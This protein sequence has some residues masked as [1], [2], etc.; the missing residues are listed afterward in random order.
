M[1]IAVENLFHPNIRITLTLIDGQI[2]YYSDPEHVS[3][4]G[5][6]FGADFDGT[7]IE[8]LP[9]ERYGVLNSS[10]FN[11]ILH[12]N[13]KELSAYSDKL[14]PGA[15]VQCWVYGAEV[16]PTVRA[17]VRE[18]TK[19]GNEIVLRCESSTAIFDKITL[20]K[21]SVT[22]AL[23]DSTA[24]D[25]GAPIPLNF[26]YCRKV[27]LPCVKND[28]TA[29]EY[30]YLLGYPDQEG[31]WED[32]THGVWYGGVQLATTTDYTY[33]D[34]DHVSNTYGYPVIRFTTQQY[35]L[36]GRPLQI[37]A[38]IKGQMLGGTAASRDFS[39]ILD[40]ILTSTTWGIGNAAGSSTY[41]DTMSTDLAAI[42]NMNCDLSITKRVKAL[43]VIHELVSICRCRISIDITD[44]GLTPL[45][46]KSGIPYVPIE[47]VGAT[48]GFYNNADVINTWSIQDIDRI[49][50]ITV[51]Y[52][53][54][55]E[56][57]GQEHRDKFEYVIDASGGN[58][59]DFTLTSVS[60]LATVKNF[61]GRIAL[62]QLLCN[63]FVEARVFPYECY[64]GSLLATFDLYFGDLD[65]LVTNG[66]AET[67][68]TTNWTAVVAGAGAATP[69][70]EATYR[71]NGDYSIEIAV[72][73]AGAA[74]TDVKLRNGAATAIPLVSG[75]TYVVE[76]WHKASAA[77][78]DLAFACIDTVT[79]DTGTEWQ[80]TR[81]TFTA[82][83][84]T[85]TFDVHIGNNGTFTFYIDDL[86]VRRLN[87]KN[88]GL[89]KGRYK[90]IKVER[91]FSDVFRV[92]GQRYC[93]R[94]YD[95]LFPELIAGGGFEDAGDVGEW[96]AEGSADLSIAANGYSGNCLKILESG[97]DNP[98]AQQ[99]ITVLPETTYRL[100][101]WHKDI[102]G[103]SDDPAYRVYDMTGSAAII[104][105]TTL[106]ASADWAYVNV[107]FTTPASCVSV[108]IYLRHTA[109]SGTADA[110]YFDEVSVI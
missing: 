93:E 9:D 26:G 10:T 17:I 107:S 52:N 96:V 4:P 6:L 101:F 7:I 78:T 16:Q 94:Q 64:M 13:D 37:Y 27:P 74:L 83:A 102:G 46:D 104:A 105:W 22:T 97:A 103:T 51:Y 73:N 23:F 109:L 39:Y 18:A 108:R 11:I 40:A 60:D 92:T 110:Y 5:Y 70:S 57:P 88:F 61:V 45:M 35:D 58:D 100:K 77:K 42:G 21:H 81:H 85:A 55:E 53:I 63:E 67:G 31:L 38:D 87:N 43:D 29:N 33:M 54:Y 19:N 44:G 24:L 56:Y 12:N 89:A 86:S 47:T 62:K 79:F 25:I 90:A 15:L 76:F 82:N 1:T 98:I 91:N 69:S 75:Q 50:T 49:G 99:T 59:I 3:Y 66:T 68:D 30:D 36:D 8:A 80:L 41:Y 48:D 71:V 20:P 14:F 2:L 28:T 34:E 65:E 72:T 106:T 95:N 84:A 32:D